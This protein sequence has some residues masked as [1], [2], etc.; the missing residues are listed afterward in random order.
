MAAGQ[1]GQDLQEILPGPGQGRR[2]IRAKREGFYIRMTSFDLADTIGL[3]LY[4]V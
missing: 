1:H 4:I 2:K 3:K